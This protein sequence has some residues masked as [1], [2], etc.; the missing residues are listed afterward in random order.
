MK[1]VGSVGN[2][3]LGESVAAPG[4]VRTGFVDGTAQPCACTGA[5]MA[6]AG[7]GLLARPA[8]D[9]R[10]S[11]A[12]TPGPR[13]TR[14]ATTV[15]HLH[16]KP[17]DPPPQPRPVPLTPRRHIEGA[18]LAAAR[19][20]RNVRGHAGGDEPRPYKG[21]QDVDSRPAF[22]SKRRYRGNDRA[23]GRDGPCRGDDRAAG[24]DGPRQG[25][26]SASGRLARPTSRRARSRPPAKW[27][28]R[29]GP[30]GGSFGRG[31]PR[32]PPA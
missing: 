25:D 29:C 13:T 5:L 30:G 20:W 1:R 28:C 23:P 22:A 14:P 4:R 2:A 16:P 32:G 24:R 26:D 15:Q 12:S 27:D 31:G 10:S 17:L 11:G 21:T 8:T 9:R 3:G 7:F 18:A 6:Y 19:G